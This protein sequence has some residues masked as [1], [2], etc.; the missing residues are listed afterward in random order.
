M[1][2]QA[3]TKISRRNWFLVIFLGMAGQI[4]WNVNNVW[5]NTFMY[6][7]ITPDP[8]AIALL[9]GVSAVIATLTT[10]VMGTAGDRL[11][12]RK[13]FIICGYLC[14]GLTIIVFPLSAN[15]AIT[16][17]AVAAAVTLAAVM[18][19][20][21]STAYDS[22]FNAWTTDISDQTNRGVLSSV[23]NVLPLVAMVVGFGLGALIDLIGYTFFFYAIGLLVS[24]T[25]LISSFL[26]KEISVLRKKSSAEVGGFFSHLFEVFS[27][28]TIKSNRELFL[29]FMALGLFA[30]SAQVFLPY[31]I[32]YME[33]FLMFSLTEA[34]LASAVGVLVAM[35][36]AIPVGRLTD[37]GNGP[38]LSFLA[39][40]LLATALWMVSFVR[41]I[42]PISI[43]LAIGTAAYI[44]M[45][46]VGIAWVKN[47]MPP[48]NRGQFEGVR[49]IFMVGIPM[50][51][52][53]VTGSS[54]ISRYGLPTISNGIEGFIPTPLLFQVAG[55][56]VLLALIPL[57]VIRRGREKN[58]RQQRSA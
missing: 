20:F 22:N 34:G 10:L 53:P 16:A 13:P 28:E 37:R 15:I 8:R 57:I 58:V 12:K 40:L 44:M 38:V 39:P 17:T 32:I 47:L 5:F 29:V 7:K 25:G 48:Q 54:I 35:F 18:T 52:G 50:I 42:I 4:A 24:I 19:F 11:G 1:Y 36:T 46:I 30:T 3:V 26:L 49:M 55:T 21:G 45:L 43:A 6:S 23:I 51:V 27:V 9:V 2:K 31:Q 33:H 14:W 56:M 41:S